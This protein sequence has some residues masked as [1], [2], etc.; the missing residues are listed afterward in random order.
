MLN[1][2]KIIQLQAAVGPAFSFSVGHGELLCL[3]GSS[4]SGK[5]LLLR[6][7]ADLDP[8]E[9]EVL[10]NDQ[11]AAEIPSPFWR[12]KIGL[13]QPTSYWW[14]DGV[15]EH[16]TKPEEAI[17]LMEKLALPKEALNWQIFRMSTGEK[18][19]MSIVRLLANSPSVLLLDEPTA[20]LDPETTQMVES[21]I[22]NY[23]KRLNTPIIWV[24]HDLNQVKRVAD[25]HIIIAGS[26]IQE[27]TL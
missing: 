25:R 3:T 10:F 5:S 19:R 24:S 7:I 20:N 11:L 26:K 2:L 18:Q 22:L 9:G 21:L 13:L 8:H 16:F 27:A 23:K 1:S 17:P 4:G 14:S 6:A 12:K 15:A